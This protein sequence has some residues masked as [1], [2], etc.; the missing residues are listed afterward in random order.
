MLYT[1][2]VPHALPVL[3]VIPSEFNALAISFKPIPPS[4]ISNI[5][6]TT[7]AFAGWVASFFL[8]T[9]P[10]VTSTDLKP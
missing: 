7:L 5:R 4:A 9:F 3:V 6:L 2:E 8:T 10:S 1:V